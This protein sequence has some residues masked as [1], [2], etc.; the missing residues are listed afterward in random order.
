MDFKMLH[1]VLS[2]HHLTVIIISYEFI[3]LNYMQFFYDFFLI[4]IY[5]LCWVLVAAC[6]I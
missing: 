6:G 4:H 1:I 5:C 3:V 2:F